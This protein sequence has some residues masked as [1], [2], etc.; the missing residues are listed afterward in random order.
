MILD[1]QEIFS[2]KNIEADICIV[3]TGAG[4][5]YAA[6]LLTYQGLKVVLVEEGP[7][8]QTNDFK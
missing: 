4:G 7:Y 2:N 5:A 8:W 3:G 1:G 6:S